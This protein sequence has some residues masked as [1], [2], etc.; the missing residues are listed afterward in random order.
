MDDPIDTLRF[1][2]TGF[3]F[4]CFLVML[5]KLSDGKMI[6]YWHW[7]APPEKHRQALAACV[8][9]LL[10]IF[11]GWMPEISGWFAGFL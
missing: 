1:V 10:F 11:F 5:W 4:F 2:A 8:F 3:F 6:W 9:F 7:D